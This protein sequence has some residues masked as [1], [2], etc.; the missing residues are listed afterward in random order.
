MIK[1]EIGKGY[2]NSFVLIEHKTEKVVLENNTSRKIQYQ[3]YTLYNHLRPLKYYT[4]KERIV[5]FFKASKLSS[6][7]SES[8][9]LPFLYS[10]IA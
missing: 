1:K 5:N 8:A 6:L 7:F 9:N 2:S 3:F 4:N 10:L